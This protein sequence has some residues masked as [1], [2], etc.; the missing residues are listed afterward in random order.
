LGAV[1]F[2]RFLKAREG[3]MAV[4]ECLREI[5]EAESYSKRALSMFPPDAV[6][7]LASAHL[8]LGNIYANAGQIDAALRHCRESI[9]LFEV[10]P[11][12]FPAGQVRW[13]AANALARAG[14]F[15]DAR[16]WAQDALRDFQASQDADKEVV[17]I[18]KL[19]GQIESELRGSSQP[20]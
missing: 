13:I 10:K 7:D 14:R 1:A 15:S 17:K 12:R 5:S 18:L 9:G 8:Q 6:G 3:N 19:L 16:E 20:S 2:R 4:E 11:N